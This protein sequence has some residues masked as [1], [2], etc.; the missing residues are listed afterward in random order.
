MRKHNSKIFLGEKFKGI[1]VFVDVITGK[2][3]VSTIEEDKV[4]FLHAEVE[5]FLP[6]SFGWID[7]RRILSTGLDQENLLVFHFF[8]IFEHAFNI[9]TFG[10]LFIVSEVMEIEPSSFDDVVVEGPG[11][12]WDIDSLVCLGV[13]TLEH[14]KAH[15]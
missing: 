4:F 3:L 7:S 11:W 13:E 6:L 15:S 9:D 14:G 1:G 10:F 5:D 2:T 12:I 8:Q